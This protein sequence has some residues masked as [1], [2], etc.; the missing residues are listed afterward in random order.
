MEVA[1]QDPEANVTISFGQSFEGGNG[2]RLKREV[3]DDRGNPFMF[4]H[5]YFGH[6]GFW[7]KT[8]DIVG[9]KVLYQGEWDDM[10]LSEGER[11]RLGIMEEEW[12]M[13]DVGEE[14]DKYQDGA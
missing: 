12:A 8:G 6:N 14:E 4:V 2:E 1:V 11:E 3:L 9:K 7:E 10:V 5:L 13:V